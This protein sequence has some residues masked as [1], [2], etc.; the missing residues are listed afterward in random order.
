MKCRPVTVT[1]AT[2][3]TFTLSVGGEVTV[4]VDHDASISAV[5]AALALS[6]HCWRSPNVEV[7]G[8]PAAY[9]VEFKGAW[10]TLMLLTWWPT[11]LR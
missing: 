7:T 1:D 8:T 5:K 6:V 9:T 3:G 10:P 4:G 2:D 11:A